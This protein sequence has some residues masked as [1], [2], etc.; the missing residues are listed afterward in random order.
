KLIQLR[1]KHEIMVYGEYHLL[2]PEDEDLYIYT[3]TLGKEQWLILC[4]FHEKEREIA[5]TQI[6]SVLLSNYTDTP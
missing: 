2:L 3:R 5:S 6:G 4:N 1:K